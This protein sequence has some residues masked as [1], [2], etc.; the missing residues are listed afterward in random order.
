MTSETSSRFAHSPPFDGGPWHLIKS[1]TSGVQELAIG[2]AQPLGLSAE[3]SSAALLHDLGKYG[4]LFQKRLKGEV[5]GIDHWT[6]G[7]WVALSKLNSVDIALAIQG[8]HIGIQYADKN[9][10][11]SLDPSQAVQEPRRLS[12]TKA[13]LLLECQTSDG[14]FLPASKFS[15]RDRFGANN[16]LRTR[17]LF[18]TLVDADFLDTE[19]HF[20]RKDNGPKIPRQIGSELNVERA[21]D[22][23]NIFLANL[24]S[25]ATNS[26][27]ELREQ[28]TSACADAADLPIG[29]FTLTA[30]TGSGKTL[31]MLRFALLHAKQHNLRRII[32]VLPFLTII[33]QTAR[34]YREIFK[35]FGEQF[36]LEDHSLAHDEG[37]DDDGPENRAKLLAENWDAPIVITTN[38]RFFEAL[39]H[40]RPSVC[41]KLH[42][43]A[44]SVVLCDEVQTLPLNVPIPS[45]MASLD[46]KQRADGVNLVAPT[47]AT[48]AS[49]AQDF[50]TSIVFATATQPAFGK[51]NAAVKELCP[52]PWE[53]REIIPEVQT[54]FERSARVTVEWRFDPEPYEQ[55]AEEVSTQPGTLV[56]LN[57][58]GEAADFAKRLRTLRPETQVFH[59][60]THMCVAHRRQ[61][62][63]RVRNEGVESHGFLVATQCV[64][65]GVDLDFCQVYRAWAPLD[66]IAQAAGRCNRNGR[67]ERGKVVVFMPENAKYPLGGY[68]QSVQAAINTIKLHGPKNAEL[69]DPE[70]FRRFFEALYRAYGVDRQ[71]SV[72]GDRI[73]TGNYVDVATLYRLIPDSGANVIL[74]IG[75]HLGPDHKEINENL[76]DQLETDGLNGNLMRKLR[77]YTVSTFLDQKDDL[78]LKPLKN[79]RGDII[80]GWFLLDDPAYYDPNYGLLS[81]GPA[82]ALIA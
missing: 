3:A 36:V 15:P 28:V 11:K 55:V 81:Q 49:L 32:V 17:M 33:E 20:A 35:E 60:S 30:P 38:V 66:S 80:P 22:A 54:M 4:D 39:H 26:V 79:R 50:G 1:H 8:H 18:S 73:N 70:L 67:V 74:R 41:R 25:S 5:S 21:L 23:L 68:K 59:L 77:A 10:L 63:Q 65:A 7:A 47:L 31:A 48:L 13:D 69:H 76:L 42:R 45:S 29:I 64:E 12:E 57:T 19:S 75:A 51:F 82:Y 6:I 62:L 40:N 34:I 44:R 2:F 14:I 78:P 46:N 53:P 61:I 24:T 27:K 52:Y 37:K 72:I 16:M 9:S 71:D 56:I 43:I 58:R